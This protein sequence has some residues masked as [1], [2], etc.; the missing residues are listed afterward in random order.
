MQNVDKINYKNKLKESVG[1]TPETKKAEIHYFDNNKIQRWYVIEE[2]AEKN[3]LAYAQTPEELSNK[4]SSLKISNID[5]FNTIL[6]YNSLNKINESKTNDRLFYLDTLYGPKNNSLRG[7][8]KENAQLPTEEKTYEQLMQ[9]LDAYPGAPAPYPASTDK[10]T[11][12]TQGAPSGTVI[13]GMGNEIDFVLSDMFDDVLSR[14]KGIRGGYEEKP[15]LKHMAHCFYE[16]LYDMR[17]K[18]LQTIKERI[19]EQQGMPAQPQQ[20]SQPQAQPQPQPTQKV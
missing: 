1:L 4:L 17:E 20:P 3:I 10:P 18:I 7:I 11:V 12:A 15:D 16:H 8:L 13:P 6:K 5:D 9:E 19:Q 2:S 14:V